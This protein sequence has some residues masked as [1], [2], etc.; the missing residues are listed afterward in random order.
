[1]S[2][3]VRD[4]VLHKRVRV[5]SVQPV[6]TS[7]LGRLLH[8]EVWTSIGALIWRIVV[9]TGDRTTD[10]DGCVLDELLSLRRICVGG[11]G[12][13]IHRWRRA[14]RGV[15]SGSS[16]RAGCQT[17]YVAVCHGIQQRLYL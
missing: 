7:E 13:R 9:W 11:V 12:A 16:T 8:A 17:R 14:L 6:L 10:E 15:G 3:K 4:L 1:M 2:D 5:D